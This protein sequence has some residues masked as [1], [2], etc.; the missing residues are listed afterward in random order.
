MNGRL[1][2]KQTRKVWRCLQHMAHN[3]PGNPMD[4]KKRVQKAQENCEA[5]QK[6]ASACYD[7]AEEYPAHEVNEQIAEAEDIL[8]LERV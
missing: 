2:G 3:Y 8:G 6:L 4:I 5:A 7:S 1:T